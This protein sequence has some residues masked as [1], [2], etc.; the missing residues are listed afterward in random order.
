MRLRHLI[1]LKGTQAQPIRHVS[2]K[3]F[4]FRH[5]SRTFMDTREP[6]LR[7]DWTIYRGGAVLFHGAEDCVLEDCHF[8][9]VGGNAVFIDDYNR[10]IHIKGCHISDAGA[11]GVAFVGHPSAV[12]SP[13]FEYHQRQSVHDIDMGKGPQN[14]RYPADCIVEDCLIYRTGRVEKQSA[15][16]QISMSMGITVRHCSIYEVPRAGI[17]VSEGTWGGHVIEY[18]DVFDTVLETGDHGA[19]NAWGRDRYWRLNDMDL[20]ELNQGTGEEKSEL[21]VLDAVKPIV[22]RNSRWRCDYGWDIDLD[23]GSSNYHIYNNVC[24]SGGIKLREGFYRICENNIM[25]NNSFHPHVWFR[26][27]DDIFRRNIVFTPYKPIRVEKPWGTECDWNLLHDPERKESEPARQLQQQ[28]GRDAHSIQADARFV[29]LENGDYRVC[30][31][32]PALQLGFQNFSMDQFG[33]QK[34]E[35]KALARTPKIPALGLQAKDSS[36]SAK[37]VFWDKCTVKNVVGL[38]EVSA[39]GLPEETGVI[40]E[41]L[42]WGCWQIGAGLQVYDVII[43]INGNKVHAVEDLLQ[44]YS[45]V[46]PGQTFTIDIFRG[47]RKQEIKCQK[48]Q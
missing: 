32:S 37:L 39:A 33:V 38:G 16:I 1:E 24:L 43:G 45:E 8:D 10:S 28:S 18:C 7:S 40:V 3:G 23:D 9:Q 19:F 27:S 15:P 13:L 34:P 17:N 5:A 26:G 20:N 11:S 2:I 41:A 35:L 44:L 30:E 14:D 6:L 4:T 29:D 12:R 42:P 48:K 25:V 31:D 47:Q 46:E 22:I 36:R 21:P